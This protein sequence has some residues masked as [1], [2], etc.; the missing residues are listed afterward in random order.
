MRPVET[1]WVTTPDG[2]IAKAV[3]SVPKAGHASVTILTCEH[4]EGWDSLKA[5]GL[6][7]SLSAGS[8]TRAAGRTWDVHLC[9]RAA[10]FR[11]C[12]ESATRTLRELADRLDLRLRQQGAWWQ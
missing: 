9:R 10:D 6:I 5:G 3:I 8:C 4:D 11:D 7:G 2:L 1:P 12:E